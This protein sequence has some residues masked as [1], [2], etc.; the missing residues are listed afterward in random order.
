M[1]ATR[2]LR[3]LHVLQRRQA[4]TARSLADEL[5]VSLRTLYRDV[6]SL[7]DAGVPLYTERGPGG[8]IRLVPGWRT[9]LDGL[10]AQKPAHCRWRVCPKRSK[11]WVSRV[12]R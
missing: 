2:L 5:Q 12:S 10:T 7:A 4:A 1:R 8:G 3:L 11:R 9:R 6:A